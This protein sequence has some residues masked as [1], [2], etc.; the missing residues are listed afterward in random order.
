[1]ILPIRDAHFITEPHA[2]YMFQHTLHLKDCTVIII[3]KLLPEMYNLCWN[4]L[5]IC[6]LFC[7]LLNCIGQ[8]AI[9]HIPYMYTPKWQKH[10]NEWACEQPL[11]SFLVFLQTKEN[12]SKK[13]N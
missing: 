4:K 9:G 12:R 6:I 8:S 10:K 5:H 2:I 1:M 11:Y 3:I 13:E 7:S